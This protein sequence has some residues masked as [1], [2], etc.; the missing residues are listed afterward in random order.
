MPAAAPRSFR[1]M[2]AARPP[3]TF[4]GIDLPRAEAGKLAEYWVGSDAV[5]AMAQLGMA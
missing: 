2:A 5:Q 4:S 1:R 3:L